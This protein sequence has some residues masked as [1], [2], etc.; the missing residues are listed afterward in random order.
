VNNIF[1]TLLALF[2]KNKGYINKNLYIKFSKDKGWGVYAK[3]KISLNIK[4]SLIKL[5][6]N[7][8]I[9]KAEM[10]NFIKSK[11]TDYICLEFLRTYLDTL[12]NIEFYKNNHPYFC[13]NIEKDLMIQILKKNFF[14]K[15]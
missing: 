2:E 9:N 5:P 13:N 1:Q 8:T 15:N 12:P 4:E 6:L 10:L 11:K 3:K 14:L 7:L